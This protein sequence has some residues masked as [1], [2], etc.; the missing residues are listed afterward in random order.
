MKAEIREIW[1]LRRDGDL[2]AA[3][4]RALEVFGSHWQDSDMFWDCWYEHFAGSRCL[5]LDFARATRSE[6]DSC[7]RGLER[8]ERWADTRQDTLGDFLTERL[9]RRI[10]LLRKIQLQ[11]RGTAALAEALREAAL[12]C[13][14]DFP[15]PGDAQGQQTTG[16]EEAA[17]TGIVS[18]GESDQMAR[19]L[20]GN[21]SRPLPAFLR[22]LEP[23]EKWLRMFGQ[24]GQQ[25]GWLNPGLLMVGQLLAHVYGKDDPTPDDRDVFKTWVLLAGRN[26]KLP[27]GM[28]AQLRLRRFEAGCGGFFPD[29]VSAGYIRLDDDFKSGLSRA[30]KAAF[31]TK[32]LDFDVAWSLQL[33]AADAGLRSLPIGGRS[34]EAAIYCALRALAADQRLD[35]RVAVTAS[36]KDHGQGGTLLAPVGAIDHKTLA[37]P[38]VLKKITEIVVSA[39]Q[40]KILRNDGRE[41]EIAN[42]VIRLIPAANVDQAYQHLVRW[43]RITS[44]V[45]K[46]MAEAAERLIEELCGQ[47]VV[48]SLSRPVSPQE[49]ARGDFVPNLSDIATKDS[50]GK[51]KKVLERLFTALSPVQVG[52][53]LN[54]HLSQPRTL[55]VANSGMGKS[56][57]LIECQRRMAESPD[58]PLPVRLVGLCEFPWNDPTQARN[59]MADSLTSFLPKDVRE[60]ERWD[61]FEW[62]VDGSQVVFLL[63]ALD[64]TIVDKLD[65]MRSFLA[66]NIGDCPVMMTG[67][68]YVRITR[69]MIITEDPAFDNHPERHWTLLR[70]DKFNGS[71][72]REFLGLWVADVLEPSFTTLEEIFEH[73]REES[74][75]WLEL[76]PVEMQRL[77]DSHA[78]KQIWVDLVNQPLL[79]KMLRDLAVADKLNDISNRRS[80]YSTAVKHLIDKGWNSLERSAYRVVFASRTGVEHVLRQIAWNRAQAGDF[81][82]HVTGEELDE[83]MTAITQG[84]NVTEREMRD[85]LDQLN[86]VTCGAIVESAQDVPLTW[87]H[88]SF[89]EYFAGVEMARNY[90]RQRMKA[91]PSGES[92]D[93]QPTNEYAAAIQN[94]DNLWEWHGT[95][96]FALSHLAA[97]D[98][99]EDAE[100]LAA[101]A[102]DL[103][104]FG[105]PFVLV[106]AIRED[107]VSLRRDLDCLCR[108]L[109]HRHKWEGDESRNLWKE[110]DP[111]P[112]LNLETAALLDSAFVPERRDRRY[113][114]PAWELVTESNLELAKSIRKRFL[115]EFPTLL[116]SG[117]PTAIGIRDGFQ[118]IPPP[119]DRS[120]NTL[121]FTLDA[122][123]KFVYADEKRPRRVVKLPNAFEISKLPVTRAQFAL[124]ESNH[125]ISDYKDVPAT[126]VS[127]Y[128]AQLYCLWLGNCGTGEPCRLPTDLEL[129]VAC[130]AGSDGP[131]CRIRLPDGTIR[132][133][134]TEEDLRQVAHTYEDKCGEFSLI[135]EGER[136]PNAWGLHDM[137]NNLDE[138]CVHCSP[139]VDP[140]LSVADGAPVCRGRHLFDER[141]GFEDPLFFTE[142]YFARLPEIADHEIFFRVA[143]TCGGI[144]D[145]RQED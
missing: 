23:R 73:S 15:A 89:F 101:L 45:R 117:N 113:L 41:V 28:L 55:V 94:A 123:A 30:W 143:R 127:W 59:R 144:V 77:I 118:E 129:E 26:T 62:L 3:L 52:D 9:K 76:D 87:Q 130:R 17:E 106:D 93:R 25:L 109:T 57:L 51:R 19:G 74:K 142:G 1:G 84:R 88:L 58:G 112:K 145:S 100:R 110:G 95:L 60:S 78:R 47:Y 141:D 69:D 136:L 115:G 125:F 103:I 86:L 14:M 22:R 10:D 50:L 31:G 40:P 107:K 67:R 11:D 71:Q 99:V 116:A 8:L 24:L 65:G 124:F 5:L 108:W 139:G 36:L 68:P 120:R 35:Q 12:A 92:Y 132:D 13:G 42:G 81:T 7:A 70:L 98:R 43:E 46:K 32:Q 104:Q 133:L 128:E 34:A 37:E 48:P 131:Y 85:G 27:T 72:Q 79:L 54:G 39:E 111:K 126:G 29:P 80:L 61:W 44:H 63:D 2:A 21:D 105:N 33:I 122:A 82:G 97:S 53:L 75:R 138:W 38:L 66:N 121:L 83:L 140:D 102:E 4:D 6:P 56:L 137:L 91:P 64:Q 134:L 18:G 135:V 90:P 114:Q 96:R 20:P 16:A 49:V 119:G